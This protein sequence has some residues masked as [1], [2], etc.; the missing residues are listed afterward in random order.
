MHFFGLMA[1]SRTSMANSSI[2]IPCD[3]A[4]RV[5]FV[6]VDRR[7]IDDPLKNKFIGKTW[8]DF[9]RNHRVENG[10]IARDFDDERWMVWIAD[11]D[12]LLAFVKKYGDII[13]SI[14]TDGLEHCFEIEIYDA[15]REQ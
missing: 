1:V 14:N 12:D 5:P 4:E 10:C 13:L 11:D 7:N 9:G 3:E 6:R 2:E 15:C 8:Y